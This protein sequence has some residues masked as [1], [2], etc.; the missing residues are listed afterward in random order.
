MYPRWPV[1]AVPAA[2]MERIRA[3]IQTA[4]QALARKAA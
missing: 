2:G 3:A 4:R 1:D